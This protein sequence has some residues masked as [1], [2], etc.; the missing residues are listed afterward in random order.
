MNGILAVETIAHVQKAACGMDLGF[1]QL[2]TG[3]PAEARSSHSVTAPTRVVSL[4]QDV[5][6]IQLGIGICA[7]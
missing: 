3:V 5:D 1:L 4:Q 2:G 7:S 6:N